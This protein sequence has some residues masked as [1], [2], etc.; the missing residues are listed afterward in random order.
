MWLPQSAKQC[1]HIGTY[2]SQQHCLTT[3]I[4]LKRDIS[5]LTISPSSVALHKSDLTAALQLEGLSTQLDRNT[6]LLLLRGCLALITT[7]THIK[8]SHPTRL[9]PGTWEGRH[10]IQRRLWSMVKERIR[11]RP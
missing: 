11:S 6:L 5:A 3:T 7:G 10:T 1:S 8:C 9:F 4:C 2:T